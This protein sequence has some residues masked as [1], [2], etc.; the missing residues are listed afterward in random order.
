MITAQLVHGLQRLSCWTL[1]LIVAIACLLGS[2]AQ[3]AVDGPYAQIFPSALNGTDFVTQLQFFDFN[4]SLGTLT[5][6]QFDVTVDLN[7][8]IEVTNSSDNPSSGSVRTEVLITLQDANS[9]LP[10]APQIDAFVPLAPWAYSIN[11]GESLSSPAFSRTILHT[12]TTSNPT[13][14]ADFSNGGLGSLYASTFTST[15]LSNTGGNT[16]A[17]QQTEARIS[18]TVTYLYEPVP[19][20]STLALCAFG[21]VSLVAIAH[22]RRAGA[23]S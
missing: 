15:L 4:T 19:E 9:L 2:T 17:D 8:G 14:L 11:A 22:R 13:I 6:V 5:G 23:K 18:A 10:G 3:A 16:S 20:P 1:G 7:T 12:E 21:L